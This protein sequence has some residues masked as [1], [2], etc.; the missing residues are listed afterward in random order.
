MHFHALLGIKTAELQIPE[1]RIYEFL[2]TSDFC[3]TAY[4][5]LEVIV[6]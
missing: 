5:V 2:G 6:F 4:R 3:D 1:K